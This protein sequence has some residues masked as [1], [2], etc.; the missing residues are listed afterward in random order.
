MGFDIKHK[1]KKIFEKAAIQCRIAPSYASVLEKISLILHPS[2]RCLSQFYGPGVCVWV[3]FPE[4]TEKREKTAG[5]MYQLVADWF[6]GV[7]S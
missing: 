2:C 1:I 4:L 6:H 7:S 5:P 3:V